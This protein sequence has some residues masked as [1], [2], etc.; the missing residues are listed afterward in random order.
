MGMENCDDC[1]D[2]RQLE[3]IQRVGRVGYWEYDVATR[4]MYLPDASVALLRDAAGGTREAYPFLLDPA[5]DRNVLSPDPAA[6]QVQQRFLRCIAANV[7]RYRCWH[8]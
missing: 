2:R 4:S 7:W 8:G 3:L 5:K 1:E 6:R